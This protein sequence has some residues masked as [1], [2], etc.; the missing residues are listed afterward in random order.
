MKLMVTGFGI[1]GS[2]RTPIAVG[3]SEVECIEQLPYLGFLVMSGGKID[4]EVNCCLA[5]ASKSLSFFSASIQW[6]YA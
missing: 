1:G 6:Q 5:N 2:D 4:A 3:D